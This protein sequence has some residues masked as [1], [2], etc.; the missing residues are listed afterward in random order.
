MANEGHIFI[1]R[2]ESEQKP[3]QQSGRWG[4][5]QFFMPVDKGSA[6]PAF[7]YPRRAEAMQ[8]ELISRKKLLKSGAL[9]GQENKMSYELK[10]KEIGKRVDEIF[11]SFERAREIIE[12]APDSWSKR[13]QT[14][15]DEI[16]ERTPTRA[17]KAQKLVNP[18]AVLREEKVGTGANRPLEEVKREYTIISRALQARGESAE[19]N[20]SFLQKDK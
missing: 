1:K 16:K 4:T 17:D 5:R 14:L 11:G 19:A 15:A 18:H 7:C 9:D 10:T 13:R 6:K 12:K 20:T 8:E 2:S 3:P